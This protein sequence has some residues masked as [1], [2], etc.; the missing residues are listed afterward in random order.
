MIRE[1]VKNTTAYVIYVSSA[2][3]NVLFDPVMCLLGWDNRYK[4][5]KTVE[6]LTLFHYCVWCM[7][8]IV[9]SFHVFFTFLYMCMCIYV[10]CTSEAK[11]HHSQNAYSCTT[12]VD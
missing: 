12:T 7:Y 1:T 10:V 3:Y 4:L 8:F 5:C 11:E 6:H 9:S 2:K